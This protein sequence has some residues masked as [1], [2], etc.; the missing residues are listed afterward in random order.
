MSNE[1]KILDILQQV[2]VRLGNVETNQSQTH[3]ELT[4]LREELN[5][6]KV[7]TSE[8]FAELREELNQLREEV[9]ERFDLLE[10]NM[11]YA[12][13]DISF[14][15]KRIKQHEKEFHDVG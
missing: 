12:W 5:Q 13:Q 7:Q 3:E 6:V 10:A 11:K 8:Q 14:V 2:L 4:E 9:G 1:E 15:E